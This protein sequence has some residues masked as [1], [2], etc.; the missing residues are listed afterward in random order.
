MKNEI[1]LRES[2]P[3]IS[4]GLDV[5]GTGEVTRST[6]ANLHWRHDDDHG[7]IHNTRG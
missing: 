3:P 2:K 4:K 6:F 7:S 5:T 1:C